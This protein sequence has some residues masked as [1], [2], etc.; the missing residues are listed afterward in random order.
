MGQADVE[1]SAG[2]LSSFGDA[3]RVSGKLL[4]ERKKSFR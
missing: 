4:R 2:T 1:D 3:G